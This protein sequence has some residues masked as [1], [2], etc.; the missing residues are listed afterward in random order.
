MSQIA[1]KQKNRDGRRVLAFLKPHKNWVFADAFVIAVSQVFSALIPTLAL[2]WLVDTILPDESNKLL[3]GLMWL[4]IFAAVADLILMVIDEYFCHQ[5]AK[6][7]TNWQKLRL[8]KHLQI[9]PFSFYQNNQSGEM[10]ARVSDD[11][12]TLHNFLAWEGSTF[13]AS[14]QGVILYSIVLLWIHPYLMITSVVLGVIFY[15]T[16]NAV[17]QRTRQS[18]ANARKQ[19]S[20]YLERLRESVTGIHLSR[21]LGVSEGEV[22]SVAEIR[23]SFIK[24][25][26]NELKAR[27]QSIVVIGSYNGLGLAVVYGLS[28]YLIWNNRLTTGEMLTAAGLVAIAANEMQ[29]MLRNW[30]S[31]RRTGPALDRSEILLSEKIS[32]A[33]TEKG[34]ILPALDGSIELREVAF[35]YPEKDEQVLKGLSFSVHPGEAVALVGP[36]GS[37]KST[38]IDLL[39]RLYDPDSGSIYIDGIDISSIDAGWLRSQIA[40]VSQDVQLR[41]GSLADNLRIAK[42][43]ATDEE[44]L[45]AI[46]DSG[47]GE[48]IQSLPDGLNTLVGERGSLLSGGQK[49]RLS[50]ARALVKDAAI[51]VLDEASSALDPITEVQV[52]EAINKRK[53][54]QTVFIISHRLSTVLAANRIIVIENGKMIEQGRH[55]TLLESENGV[56]SRLFKREAEIGTQAFSN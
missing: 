20:R 21:V 25:S 13:M 3:W 22:K 12:D 50:L 45:S 8:F 24:E 41:N 16:S 42:P 46:H 32:S 31:V 26:R 18:S 4:L 10:M 35:G 23:K 52:N 38:I 15:L 43:E 36:S 33:E 53:S 49:Q 30:L 40:I 28:A 55:E 34:I 29:R 47:L 54:K 9:L 17:G 44:L 51:L 6:T 27:M 19:A 2:G 14:V 7:V 39:L 5:V 56:Y 1:A 37:G 48:F 11:P